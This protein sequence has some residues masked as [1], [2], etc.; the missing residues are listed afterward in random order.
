MVHLPTKRTDA[1]VIHPSKARMSPG[2][3]RSPE[4]ASISSGRRQACRSWS[5]WTQ[6]TPSRS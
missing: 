6:L 5:A 4:L 1:I 2:V 3:F